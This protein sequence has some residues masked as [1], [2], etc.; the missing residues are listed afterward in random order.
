MRRASR[1]QVKLWAQETYPEEWQ[2]VEKRLEGVPEDCSGEEMLERL[3]IGQLRR[4][5]QQNRY[6]VLALE[7]GEKTT[8]TVQHRAGGEG[9][10][11]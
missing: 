9:W 4:L 8:Q 3:G 1:S 11:W 6:A 5:A 2:E 10:N 7:E